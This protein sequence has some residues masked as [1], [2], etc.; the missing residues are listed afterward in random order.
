LE[1]L[2][3]C[4]VFISDNF[5]S[6]KLSNAGLPDHEAVGGFFG[7]SQVRGDNPSFEG[8]NKSGVPPK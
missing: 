5:V 1:L 4:L 6:V 2:W 8:G 3:N 7:A